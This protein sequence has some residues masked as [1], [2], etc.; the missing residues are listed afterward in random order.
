MTNQILQRANNFEI[1]ITGVVSSS[2]F[3]KFL[4]I[5]CDRLLVRKGELKGSGGIKIPSIWEIFQVFQSWK[6]VIKINLKHETK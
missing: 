4:W 2:F 3:F 5:V 6:H 1:Y